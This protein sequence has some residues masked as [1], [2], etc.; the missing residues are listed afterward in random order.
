MTENSLKVTKYLQRNYGTEKSKQ[1]I[2]QELGLPLAAVIGTVNALTKKGLVTE[3]RSEEI[4]DEPATETRKAKT[5]IVRYHTLTEAGLT[6]D[7]E[8]EEAAKKAAKEAEK[9]AKKAAKEAE[10]A[11]KEAN[12]M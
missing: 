5:H 3:T 9:A 10:K 2:A 6:Y 1:E 12:V 8:A 11:A 7:P 4:V